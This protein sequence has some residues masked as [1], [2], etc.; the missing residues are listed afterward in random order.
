[1]QLCENCGQPAAFSV[2]AVIS[3]IGSVPRRQKCTTSLRFCGPCLQR[4][5]R[6][7][8]GM[9]SLAL[10]GVMQTAF[11]ALTSTSAGGTDPARQANEKPEVD[12]EHEKEN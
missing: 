12:F 5:G 3:T 6:V 11:T 7:D 4:L 2:C 8:A 10:S 9:S 1:M